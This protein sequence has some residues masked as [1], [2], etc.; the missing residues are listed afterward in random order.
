VCLTA[1]AVVYAPA[2]ALTWPKAIP[3]GRVLAALAGLGVVCTA[4]AFLL[5]FRLIA[6]VGPARATVITYVNPAVAV[7]LGVSVLGE[8]LTPEIVAAF[9][10]ILA[11]SVLATRSGLRRGAPHGGVPVRDQQTRLESPG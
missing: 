1:A 10:L 8:P 4:A 11:G 6:E 2:A 5:F 3:P 7:A 9:A